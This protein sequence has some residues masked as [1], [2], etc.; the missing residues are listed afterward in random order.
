MDPERGPERVYLVQRS[1]WAHCH[2][3]PM[4]IE[5]QIGVSDLIGVGGE[6]DE[7]GEDWVQATRNLLLYQIGCSRRVAVFDLV[8]AA[9][10]STYGFLRTQRDSTISRVRGSHRTLHTAATKLGI[11]T[12]LLF[13]GLHPA[14]LCASIAPTTRH[15]FVLTTCCMRCSISSLTTTARYD[16][17]PGTATYCYSR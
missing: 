6:V 14:R 7:V 15:G 5:R 1:H 9:T 8:S 10:E 17:V 2:R 12:I 4:M 3:P 11:I 13:L 16:V